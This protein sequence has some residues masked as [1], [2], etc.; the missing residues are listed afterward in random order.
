MPFSINCSHGHRH[1]ERSV[2]IQEKITIARRHD[3]MDSPAQP[4][5]SYFSLDCHASL[6]MTVPALA[7]TVPIEKILLRLSHSMTVRHSEFQ[8]AYLILPLKPAT[9]FLIYNQILLS[10]FLDK[11]PPCG[12]TTPCHALFL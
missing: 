11:T 9:P 1:C 5:Y 7:M 6:A 2:A 3:L 4:H 12:A 10:D 8:V